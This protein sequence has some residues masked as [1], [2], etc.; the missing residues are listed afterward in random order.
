MLDYM[1][2][3][4]I[5]TEKPLVRPPS[6]GRL[7]NFATGAT[8]RL[9]QEM[10]AEHDLLLA[11]WVVLAALWQRD[12]L[13]V[14]DIARYSGNNLPAASRIVDRM[15]EKGLVT[16]C[17]DDQDRRAVRVHL[18]EAGRALDGLREFHRDVNAVLLAGL[19]E[20]EAAT[21]FDLLERV[22]ANARAAAPSGPPPDAG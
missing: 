21:L 15:S 19:S 10:L 3:S 22:I 14:S 20:A 9:C 7:L 6:L 17:R 8:N 5:E 13:H 16:R 18:T 1:E 4:Y 11:Q 2:M 12:G